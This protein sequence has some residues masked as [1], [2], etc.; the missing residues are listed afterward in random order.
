MAIKKNIPVVTA[1]KALLA[2][3]GFEIAKLAQSKNVLI[4]YEAKVQHSHV[5]KNPM[6]HFFNLS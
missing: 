5:E 4:G 2:I 1:N 6:T 3:H